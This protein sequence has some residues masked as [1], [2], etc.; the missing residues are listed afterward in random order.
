MT[1][2]PLDYALGAQVQRLAAWALGITVG[3]WMFFAAAITGHGNWLLIWALAN[4]IGVTLGVMALRRRARLDTR[5]KI[6]VRHGRLFAWV[7]IALGAIGLALMAVALT[8]IFLFIQ[9]GGFE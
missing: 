5:N 6:H 3:G 9:S 2:E 1:T 4:P 8:L 7:S